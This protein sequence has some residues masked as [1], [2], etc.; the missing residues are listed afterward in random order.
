MQNQCNEKEI[1]SVNL[2]NGISLVFKTIHQNKN[3]VSRFP[4]NRTKIL[5]HTPLIIACWSMQER[6]RP[7][8]MLSNH[9]YTHI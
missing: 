7:T 2:L 9:L 3:T 4:L 8:E 1:G 6:R 5:Q